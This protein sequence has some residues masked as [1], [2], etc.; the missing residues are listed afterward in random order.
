VDGLSASSYKD[1]SPNGGFINEAVFYLQLLP[2]E[3]KRFI[4]MRRDI[5]AK[6]QE[7]LAKYFFCTNRR[8]LN[9]VFLIEIDVV[10]KKIQELGR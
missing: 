6:H 1:A 8:L 3:K 5:N 7:S 9:G 10:T 2:Q 4:V